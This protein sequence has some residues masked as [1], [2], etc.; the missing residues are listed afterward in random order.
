[1][2]ASVT[3]VVEFRNAS[4]WN[5]NVFESF[6]QKGIAFCSVSFPGLPADNIVTGHVFY[7][8]M[9]G[10]P[11]LFESSYADN[12]LEKLAKEIPLNKESWIYFNNTMFEAGYS[13]ALHL[14]SLVG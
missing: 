11:K 7:K 1:L 9:H 14:K 3:S 8:R 6:R 4:W 12:E 2:D 10:I 5:Q 13:N